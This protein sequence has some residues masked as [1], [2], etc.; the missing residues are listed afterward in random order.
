MESTSTSP[1]TSR[2]GVKAKVKVKLY[3]RS[4]FVGLARRHFCAAISLGYAA[5]RK[6]ARVGPLE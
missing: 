3:V 5:C 1:F 6:Q 4:R 2:N